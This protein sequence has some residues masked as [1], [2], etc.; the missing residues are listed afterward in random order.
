MGLVPFVDGGRQS[1]FKSQLLSHKPSYFESNCTDRSR[2]FPNELTS[3]LLQERGLWYFGQFSLRASC[4]RLER[5][6]KFF[7]R[8]L[9]AR[10]VPTGTAQ[11]AKDGTHDSRMFTGLA[12]NFSKLG[13]K[14]ARDISVVNKRLMQTLVLSFRTCMRAVG[15]C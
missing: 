9:R 3:L 5:G 7:C 4:Q 6:L 10:R 12:Q 14:T 15:L 1:I 11:R 2:A 13:N 8:E